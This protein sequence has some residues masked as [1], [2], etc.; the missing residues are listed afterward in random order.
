MI[1]RVSVVDP[2]D[3]FLLGPILESIIASCL[4]DYLSEKKVLEGLK[5]QNE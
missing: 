1:L 4:K 3:Y 5:S 2:L